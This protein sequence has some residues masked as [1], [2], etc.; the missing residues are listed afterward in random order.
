MNHQNAHWTA[1][2]INFKEKRVESYDSMGIAK[3]KVFTVRISILDIASN[4]LTPGP[5]ASTVLYRCRTHEQEEKAFRFHRLEKLGSRRLYFFFLTYRAGWLIWRLRSR[6]RSKRM[7]LTVVYSLV[8][9]WKPFQGVRSLSG[10][11]KRICHIFGEGWYGRLAMRH[12]V[13]III[14]FHNMEQF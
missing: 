1:A 4:Y 14:S 6:H 10:F 5:K 3:D 13:M 9:S 12:F 7:G 8:S 2:A 11:L